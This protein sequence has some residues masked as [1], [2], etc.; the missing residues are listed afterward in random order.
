[1]AALS[2][3]IQRAY[4]G[5]LVLYLIFNKFIHLLYYYDRSC[6]GSLIIPEATIPPALGGAKGGQVWRWLI[7]RPFTLSGIW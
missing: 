6:A 3:T 5:P 2:A 4:R 7:W 1:L